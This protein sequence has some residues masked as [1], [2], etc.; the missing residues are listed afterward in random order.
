[1]SIC[2]RFLFWQARSF[3]LNVQVRKA[4]CDW[5]GAVAYQSWW[6]RDG[7]DWLG[8]QDVIQH[9][10]GEKLS[11]DVL[12]DY[13]GESQHNL[14]LDIFL[15]EVA[16]C[17]CNMIARNNGRGGTENIDIFISDSR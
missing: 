12:T 11:S 3:H 15:L 13:S 2:V 16:G 6:R 14:Q 4:V 10:Q 9:W 1:M 5:G 8:P 7:L 17:D